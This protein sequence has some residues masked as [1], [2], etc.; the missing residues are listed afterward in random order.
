M[1]RLIALLDACVLYP[2]ALR[3]F[4]LHLAVEDLYRPK[5]T[6]AIHDEWIRNV[7]AARPDLR[8]EQ[9][10]RTRVLMNT[11]ADDSVVGGYESLIES[12][13]LPDPSDRH[14]LAAAIHGGADV[15]V[16][17][18]LR[19]FPP[20]ALELHDLEAVHPDHFVCQLLDAAPAEVCAAACRQRA[21]LVSPPKSADEL[22][23]TLGRQGLPRTVERL[24]PFADRL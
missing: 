16:T 4:F 11:H 14:V 7:L 20:S 9:L 21:M 13:N 12:L 8:R 24:R 23:G 22:L 6:E 10:E 1:D 5:W 3:D 15:I 18:N 19:D 17:F 2:A